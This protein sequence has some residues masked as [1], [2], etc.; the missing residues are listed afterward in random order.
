MDE[1][2]PIYKELFGQFVIDWVQSFFCFTVPKA[3]RDR[4]ETDPLAH[5]NGIIPL[6]SPFLEKVFGS[7]LD[8]KWE[9]DKSNTNKVVAYVHPR[10]REAIID[11]FVFEQVVGGWR[12]AGRRKREESF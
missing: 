7:A 8:F 3:I 6:E 11:G 9:T 5:Y 2:N 12:Y 4:Y 10:T 1:E